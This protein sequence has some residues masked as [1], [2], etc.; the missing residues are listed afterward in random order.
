M[1]IRTSLHQL[2]R[3]CAYM[4]LIVQLTIQSSDTHYSLSSK[5]DPP[6][7]FS[8]EDFRSIQSV[9]QYHGVSIRYRRPAYP[10]RVPQSWGTLHCWWRNSVKACKGLAMWAKSSKRLKYKARPRK[11]W[12]SFE[13]LGNGQLETHATF[14]GSAC[15]PS[16]DMTW[17][18]Y[19]TLVCNKWHFLGRIFNPTLFQYLFQLLDMC[20]D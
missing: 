10:G 2:T 6:L 3:A 11:L 8:F 1:I 14:C 19:C 5:S 17:P 7:Q 4:Q 20:F 16:A 18:R 15:M 9:W 13:V 12:S